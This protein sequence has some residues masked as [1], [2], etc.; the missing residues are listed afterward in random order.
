MSEH[1]FIALDIGGVCLEIRPERCFG[2]LGYR[3]IGEVPP[4]LLAGVERYERGRIGEAEFLALFRDATGSD[5]SDDFIRSAWNAILAA[6]MPGMAELVRELQAA[7]TDI[8][9]FSDTSPLHMTEFRR[10]FE[11]ARLLPDGVYSFVV[12]ARKPDP[13]MFAALEADYGKPSLYVDDR[14]LCLSGAKAFGWPVCRFESVKQ[15]RS[16]LQERDLL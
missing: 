3:S 7:G 5:L 6:E 14:E 15:L 16:V 8:V 10:R 13:A 4:A 9:L 1:P 11:I 2:L 12:G